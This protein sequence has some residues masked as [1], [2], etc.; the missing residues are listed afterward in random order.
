[1]VIDRQTGGREKYLGLVFD[2]TNGRIAWDP[3]SEL[4]IVS[5]YSVN[6]YILVCFGK[7]VTV[8]D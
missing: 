6:I 1:V 7:G 5:E 3:C 4:N 2:P 8:F